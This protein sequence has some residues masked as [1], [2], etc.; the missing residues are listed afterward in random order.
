MTVRADDPKERIMLPL[1]EENFPNGSWFKGPKTG[2]SARI[3]R[4]IDTGKVIVTVVIPGKK[5]VATVMVVHEPTEA[6][7]TDPGGWNSILER[8]GILE[9]VGMLGLSYLKV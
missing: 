1:T 4:W 6:E 5:P 8:K 2:R 3:D 7:P 9:W